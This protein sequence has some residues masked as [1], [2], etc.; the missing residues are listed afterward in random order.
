MEQT[1]SAPRKRYPADNY[2]I[3]VKEKN[4]KRSRLLTP[5]GGETLRRVHATTIPGDRVETV[6]VDLRKHNPDVIF[7]AVPCQRRTR[8]APQ[9]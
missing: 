4:D 3:R 9:S 6:L 1:N 2:F 8:S 5:N 7:R